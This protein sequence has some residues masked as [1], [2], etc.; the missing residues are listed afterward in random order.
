M[1]SL[2]NE[3]DSSLSMLLQTVETVA[4][5]TPTEVSPE[6]LWR[7]LVEARDGNLLN[8]ESE[9]TLN[10]IRRRWLET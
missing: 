6:L 2:R 3:S 4:S 7:H 9:G 10:V 1:D 8:V 5:M